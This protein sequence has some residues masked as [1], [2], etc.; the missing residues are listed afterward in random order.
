MKPILIKAILLALVATILINCKKKAEEFPNIKGPSCQLSSML[1]KDQSLTAGFDISGRLS[2]LTN[3]GILNNVISYNYNFDNKFSAFTINNGGDLTKYLKVV[4]NN[5]LTEYYIS[6]KANGD[7]QFREPLKRIQYISDAQNVKV[8]MVLFQSRKNETS[9]YITDKI[10]SLSYKGKNVIVEKAI[11]L[12]STVLYT[13]TFTYD[14]LSSPFY[15]VEYYIESPYL[16][17]SE[18]NTLSRKLGTGSNQIF[19]YEYDIRGLPTKS[20][21]PLGITTYTYSCR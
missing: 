13:N 2:S 16:Y 9:A 8:E 15:R 19:S 17:L 14:S 1:S 7:P 3:K 5:S 4:Q 12:D 6:T 18:N 21:S 10:V 11:K 20:T